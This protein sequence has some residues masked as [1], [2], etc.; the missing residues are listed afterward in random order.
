MDDIFND[1]SEEETRRRVILSPRN[2]DC[3]LNNEEV[4]SQLPGDFSTYYSKYQ[5]LTDDPAE[6]QRYLFNFQNTL[7]PSG[8]L[9]IK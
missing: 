5:I 7:T 3:I 2:T 1:I 4:L 8:C 9:L 6:A